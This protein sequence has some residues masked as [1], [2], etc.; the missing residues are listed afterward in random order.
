[1]AKLGPTLSPRLRRAIS[2]YNAGELVEAEQ[3]C[4]QIISAKH[5][6]F[7]ALHLLSI[8]Q[9]RLGKK[10]MALASY[11]RA[12]EVRPDSAEAL[13]SRGNILRELKRFEDALASYDRALA[14]RPDYPEALCNRAV[15]LHDLKRFEEALAS[16]DRALTL[17]P[18][19]TEALYNR[20]NTLH[21]L[22]RFEKALASYDRALTERPDFAEAL[23]NRGNALKELKRFEQ[24][25]ASYDRA[26]TLRPD[27]AG[28]LS[29]RG[30]ALHQLKRFD[31]A[32]ASYDRAL[33]LRP[34][35][36]EALHNRGN[37][38]HE[39]KRFQDALTSYDRAF[40][41]RPDHAEALYSR[42]NTLKELKRF[43]EALA[44]YD[45][46]LMVR[47]DSAEALSSR[48]NTL[49]ELKRFEEALASYDRA[50]ALQPDF[51][52]VLSNRGVTLH[53]L[54]RYEEALASY[55]RAFTLQPDFAE[56]LYNRGNTLKELKR[57]DE[58]LASYDRALTLRPDF[59]EA[60]S[61]RGN[62]LKELKRFE[63]A[64]ASYDR[65]LALRPDYD[66]THNSLGVALLQLGHLSEARAALEQAVKLAPRKAK[67]RRDLGEITRFVAE[68][69]H[70]AAL[71]KLATDSAALSA[72][73]RIELHFA[74]GKAYE[75]VGRHA[76]AFRQ[77]LNGNA[78][79]RQQI[80]YNE[81]ATLGGLDRV[82]SVFT[83]ELIR[84][85]QDVGDP[86]PVPVFIVGMAR[87]GTTLIEQILASHP[88][89]FGGGELTS[90]TQAG[91]GIR[92]TLGGSATFPELM[93]D[94][95]STDYRNLGARYLAEIQRLA[96]DSIRITDKAP[97]NFTFAGLIHLALPNAQIIHTVRDPLDTC[98]SCFS[99]LFNEGQHH[100][101]D[102]AELGRYYRH[103]Q[104]LMAHW[105]RVLPPGRILD[106]HYED[107]VADLEG[108]ARRI[109]AHCGLNWDPRCL[110]FHQTKRPVLTASAAQVRQPIY[111]SA[112]GRSR[113]HEEAL[114][115]LLEQLS[116]ARSPSKLCAVPAG[117]NLTWQFS[118][119][120]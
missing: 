67:Y 44:S 41:V 20:G 4:Q 100:T 47:P 29:N 51:A 106:V 111:N 15:T 63:E 55:D 78:L 69:A 77:W 70:L 83:S 28:A 36:V 35:Y 10:D 113:V 42:G 108:Q 81:A 75:D 46:A 31:E 49:K 19:S 25:L 2:A 76:E 16:Y 27:Y 50:L 65:A 52:E 110:A 85:W 6:L 58:A 90:F 96:P 86:S 33:T 37:T 118:V 56:A 12:L 93:S 115:P 23:C 60:F 98:L 18:D 87:S 73:D 17:R 22:K 57:F 39:L 102:L 92:T 8:I 72:G 79:K 32:L 9:S 116:M 84:K 62:T 11:D 95:T 114:G 120:D 97:G 59:A 54:K 80:T 53:G 91:Q 48:G 117:R 112:V 24:A 107:A 14:V 74:L 40:T 7:D 101:Y 68:D 94:M 88:Q 109:I 26:L 30:V 82:R 99:K 71:E 105:H 5:D 61:N 43:E 13:Y 103:Y 89:V 119:T 34:D 45:R 21:E 1:M 3:I 104:A 66:E 64:L 38:L